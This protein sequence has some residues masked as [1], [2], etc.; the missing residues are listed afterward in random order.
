[1][2]IEIRI[3]IEPL[4]QIKAAFVNA[5]KGIKPPKNA[6]LLVCHIFIFC[7]IALLKADG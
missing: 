5:L 3:I 6:V 2:R 7:H 1:M 4:P